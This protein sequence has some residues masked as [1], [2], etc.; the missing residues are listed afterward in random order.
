MS[1]PSQ[2]ELQPMKVYRRLLGYSLPHWRIMVLAFLATSVFAAVDASFAALVK[3]LLDKAFVEQNQDYIRWLPLAIVGLFLLRGFAAFASAYGMAWVA[4]RVVKDVRGALFNHLLTLPTRFYDRISSGQL[5]ARLTYHVEQVADAVTGVLTTVLKDGLTVIALVTWMFILNW[6]LTSF[7]FVVVPFIALIIRYVSRRFRM[8][9]GRIQKSVSD[10]TDSAEEAVSGQRIIKI[11]NGQALEGTRFARV[12]ENNRWLSMKV[13]ATQAGSAAL[14]QFIAAWAVAAIVYYA[15]QPA[16]LE[17]MTPG[18]F[19]SFMLAMLSLLQPIKSMGNINER[20]Q[21]GIA[22]GTEIFALLNEPPEPQGGDRPLERAQGRIEFDRVQFRY[23]DELADALRGISL[24]I[25]P[26][27]TVAFV[28]RSGSG[29]STLLSLLPRFYDVS[30]GAV[31][32]DGHDIR[33]YPLYQLRNQIALVDQ[34]VRLF[35]ASVAD[36]IS[37]GLARKPGREAIVQAARDAYAWEFIEKLPQGLDTLI[38][39]NGQ[40][41]SGGQRQRIAIARAL[42]KDAPILILDEAT[43]AL[44]TESERY[45]QAALERLVRGRTTLVIAHRLSTVQHA[46]L[47]VVLQDGRIIESGRHEQLLARNGLYAALYQMQFDEPRS[48]A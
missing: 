27:Q 31:R 5:I 40:T 29:K 33:E 35:N 26:G 30:E 4:R 47:I 8:I 18:S 10:V 34:Q 12:N 46:D 32:L 44:D 42:L 25:E 3:P 22:A 17:V 24:K 36:N 39:Q 21:R 38:G 14:I 20:L 9:S 1:E 28:G 19:A 16:M 11:Y 15:T 6:Q 2:P 45:I 13:V 23:R 37:Y 43:S 48:A 41:L 7:A